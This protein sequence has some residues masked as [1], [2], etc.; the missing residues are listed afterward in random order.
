MTTTPLVTDW[1][2][3][4]A[5]IA[6]AVG[7]VSA[8]FT[9]IALVRREARRDL[10]Q[11]QNERRAQARLVYGFISLPDGAE[12]T[13]LI[14]N[15]SD[16]PIYRLWVMRQRDLKDF[17]H[18]MIPGK[19]RVMMTVDSDEA[20]WYEAFASTY[21]RPVEFEFTDANSI[22]WRRTRD[23]QLLELTRFGEAVPGASPAPIR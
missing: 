21:A 8:L 5:T 12:P 23:G 19:Q 13:I 11:R 4:W 1:I 2:L 22:T 9:A 10:A 15:D 17:W 3:A 18:L 6:G 7:T 14:V 20:S 16:Q